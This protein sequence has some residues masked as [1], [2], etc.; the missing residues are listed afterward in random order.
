MSSVI[1]EKP[2]LTADP[3]VS[4]YDQLS[5]LLVASVS[6]VGFMVFL[7][8]L[9][10]LTMIVDWGSPKPPAVIV[11]MAG[12]DNRPEGIA[13]D[14]QPPGVEEFP[15]VDIPQLADALEATTDAISSVRAQLEKVDGDAPE[16]G[17]GT[18]LGD[19]R[20]RGPGSGFGDVIPEADRW[21]IEIVATTQGEYMKIL[22]HF[23]IT[24]GVVHELSN[25]IEYVDN[26]TAAVSTVTENE[27]KNEGRLFFMNKKNRLRK[28]DQNKVESV[29]LELKNTLVGHFYSMELR[30]TM[31]ALEQ[32][33]Y[34]KAGK[35]LDEVKK[36]EFR[37]RPAGSGYEYFIPPN[38]IEFRPKPAK[39]SA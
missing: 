9:I 32:E 4:G 30:A 35:G 6:V 10:W 20:A 34:L 13:D 21:K 19:K 8:F 16:M 36:T 26:L 14:W 12:N 29:G 38:G 33:V 25:L 15:E 2:Q 28:W 22:E 5:A 17:T 27:R 1:S 3:R 18:G 39:P 11:E 7:M 37:I 31:L 24:I 23:D